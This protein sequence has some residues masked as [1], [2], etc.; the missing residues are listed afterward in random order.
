M[1]TTLFTNMVTTTAPINRVQSLL[2]D[3]SKLAA[4][5]QSINDVQVTDQG[6]KLSRTDEAINQQELLQIAATSQQVIYLG[7]GPRLSYQLIFKL[8]TDQVGTL[9]HEEFM[10]LHATLPRP[11]LTLLKPT[12]KKAFYRNLTNLVRL[13]E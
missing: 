11:F 2:V 5:N 13:A 7:Q 1:T 10:V 4:W 8:T 6:A 12:A 9:I 3:L